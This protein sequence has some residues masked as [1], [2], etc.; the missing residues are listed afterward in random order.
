MN[1][2][3]IES[4]LEI[5]GVVKVGDAFVFTPTDVDFFVRLIVEECIGEVEQEKDNH[6]DERAL[7]MAIKGILI[8]FGVE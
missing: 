4:L 2:K 1:T 8:R 3:L 6:D 5:A 7:E